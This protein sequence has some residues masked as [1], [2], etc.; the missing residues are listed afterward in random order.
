VVI[1]LTNKDGVSFDK[2]VL[3]KGRTDETLLEGRLKF[4]I[5]L[6]ES[7]SYIKFGQKTLPSTQSERLLLQSNPL[8]KLKLV[9]S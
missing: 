4:I 6:H 9:F 3:K 7:L 8:S 5:N 2:S 1:I